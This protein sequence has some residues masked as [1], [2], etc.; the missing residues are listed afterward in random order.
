MSRRRSA[1]AIHPLELSVLIGLT[2]ADVE[3]KVLDE[4]VEEIPD[5]VACDLAAITVQTFTARRAYRIADGLRARGIPVV[6]GGYHPTLLP[7]EAA[8]HAD[9]V[10]IGEAEGI[11]PRLV[12][13]ARRGD[14]QKLYRSSGAAALAGIRYPRDAFRGKRYRSLF[15]VEISRGC[16]F[17]CE[18]CSVSSFH[19]GTV[20]T[21]PLE[22]IVREVGASAAKLVLV[23]DDNISNGAA[24]VRDLARAFGTLR[25][26]WACQSSLDIA[27]DGAVLDEMAAGGCFAVLVGFESL[28]AGN[29]RQ[30]GK[31]VNLAAGD[32]RG[33]I[34]A[35]RDRGIMVFGSFVLGYDDD[36]PD[37]FSRTVDFAL[38]EKLFL[39]NFNTLSP[40]PGTRLYERLRRDGRL[41][42]EAWWLDRRFPYGEVAF[43]PARMSADD[44]RLGCLEA[45]RSFYRC[46]SIATRLLEPRAN[47]AGPARAML[48]LVTNLVAR[49]EIR[50]KMRRLR[51]AREGTGRRAPGRTAAEAD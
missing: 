43:R 36:G 11:W 28:A 23:V 8:I 24:Y 42:S 22:E 35:L 15:P 19:A 37:I 13:D 48:C 46:S 14:L 51:Q 41:L 49:R 26:S 33:A 5:D 44:L 9:S 12:A 50:S 10:V 25:V 32:F 27:G 2:P 20:R 16:R 7:A 3:V 34:R 4:R 38:E 47:S 39:C 45:R 40:M 21:R 31:G 30:M 17:D 18:F 1:D 29:L 6:L